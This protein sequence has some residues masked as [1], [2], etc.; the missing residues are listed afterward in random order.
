MSKLLPLESVVLAGNL[1][2]LRSLVE[3]HNYDP[4]QKGTNGS[5]L[6]HCACACGN[7]DMVKYLIDEH[8]LLTLCPNMMLAKLPSIW[9]VRLVI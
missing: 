3:E 7:L 8:Q 4:K 5:T 6:L 1:N 9:L 2:M